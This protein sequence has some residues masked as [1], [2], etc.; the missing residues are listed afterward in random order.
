MSTQPS[1]NLP[2]TLARLAEISAS[3]QSSSS[4]LLSTSSSLASLSTSAFAS[5][6]AIV[7]EQGKPRRVKRSPKVAAYFKEEFAREFCKV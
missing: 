1:S 5:L 4:S 7:W 6:P 3:C 2:P